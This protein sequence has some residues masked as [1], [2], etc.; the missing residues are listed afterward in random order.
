VI[1]HL[2]LKREDCNLEGN[3]YDYTLDARWAVYHNRPDSVPIAHVTFFGAPGH[4]AGVPT[5]QEVRITFSNRFCLAAQSVAAR[6]SRPTGSGYSEQPVFTL[7]GTPHDKRLAWESG[8]SVGAQCSG[9]VRISK[10]FDPDLVIDPAAIDG[11]TK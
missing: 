10:S 5:V 9:G 8:L 11:A 2:G 6:V 1:Q 3:P 7:K 4:L